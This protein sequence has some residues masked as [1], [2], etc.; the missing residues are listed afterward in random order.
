[1]TFKNERWLR[2]GARRATLDEE[3]ILFFLNM[4]QMIHPFLLLRSKSSVFTLM[5][6]IWGLK[7]VLL[8]EAALLAQAT[9]PY[10]QQLHLGTYYQSELQ[11][12]I[13]LLFTSALITG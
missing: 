12:D 11:F 7:G 5:C 1:M 13:L 6:Q 3:K 9:G 8:R 2:V 10:K 4:A